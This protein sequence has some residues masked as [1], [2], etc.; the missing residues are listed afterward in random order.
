MK[1]LKKIFQFYVFSNIHVSFAVYCFMQITGFLFD[2]NTD[3]ESFFVA[4]TTFVIYHIIRYLNKYKYGKTHLLDKFSN[5]Y[6]WI[7]IVLNCFAFFK[8]CYLISEF[9]FSQVLR[10]FPFGLITLLYAFSVLKIGGEKLSIR[11]I[12]GLKIFVIAFVWAGVGVFLSLDFTMKTMFYFLELMLFVIVLTLPFDIRDTLFDLGKIK[13]LPILLG[14]CKTKYLGSTFL[15]SALI[16]HNYNFGM[17]G[18]WQFTIT[19]LL[20]LFML[21]FSKTK[22]SKYFASFWVEG[23]PIFYFYLLVYT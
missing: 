8:S 13:T 10:L 15:I 5:K 12:P 22:Q 17:F 1:I 3:N 18:L 2:I 9:E 19:G 7:L 20:L 4:Y 11:Y 16:L 21:W 6:K 23:V 14:I